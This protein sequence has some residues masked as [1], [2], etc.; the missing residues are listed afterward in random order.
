MTTLGPTTTEHAARVPANLLKLAR[1]RSGLSQRQVAER[2]GVPQSMVACIET[3]KV[4]PS[5]PVLYR[6]LVQGTG[7]EPRIRLEV[8]DD[9][10]T[11]LDE[12]SVSDPQGTPRARDMQHQ[13]ERSAGPSSP[14]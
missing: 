12:L 1:T 8:F 6:I 13:F 2:A 11:I 3:G 10:D 4:Q 7:L 9:H 5:F 14:P